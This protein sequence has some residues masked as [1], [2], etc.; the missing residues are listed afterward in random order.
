MA[1]AKHFMASADFRMAIAKHFMASA[2][3]RMAIAKHFVASAE[4]RMA[5]MKFTMATT[6]A[7]PALRATPRAMTEVEMALWIAQKSP[8]AGV[9]API[10]RARVRGRI[11]LPRAIRIPSKR[12]TCYQSGRGKSHKP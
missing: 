10:F 6:E 7:P 11:R 2:K 3:F 1:I 12:R 9:I 4:A 5:M 8:Q